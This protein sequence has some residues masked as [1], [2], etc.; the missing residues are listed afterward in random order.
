M[1]AGDVISRMVMDVSGVGAGLSNAEQQLNGFGGKMK[2]AG[3]AM[4]LALSAPLAAAKGYIVSQTLESMSATSQLRAQLGLTADEAANLGTVAKT[5]WSSGFGESITEATEAVSQVR[6]NMGELADKELEQVSKGAMML[7][8]VFQADVGES[9]AAAGVLM[10]NFKISAQDSFD[11]ITTGFQQGGDYSGEL[12]DTLREYSPQFSTMG[13]SADQ[14]LGI[15]IA[16]A[17]EGAWNLDKVGDAVKE[18]NIRAKDGSKT[19]VDGFA[20]IGLNAKQM[21]AAIAEGGEKG[22]QAFTATLA[23]LAAMEDPVKRNV[24]G[25]ALFGTQWED[26]ESK[27]V[28][29]MAEG[30]KGVEGFQ[31]STEKAMKSLEENNPAMAMKQ[32]V[33]ELTSSVEPALRPI[34]S[35]INDDVI[36]AAKSVTKWFTDLGPA[37]QKAALGIAALVLVSGPA[38]AGLGAV[39]GGASKV[40]TM[41]GKFRGASIAASV[42]TQGITTA[43]TTAT[44]VGGLAGL[45]TSLGA[46]A[47]AAGPWLLASAAIVGYSLS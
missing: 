40:I 20:A 4:S 35:I 43:T 33:R 11:L 22:Q 8:R 27:V 41:L 3:A 42:A 24:A 14:M 31:G 2:K 16:G 19:T 7:S 5:T 6:H 9:T 28:V 13:M 44:G 32:S 21:G 15:L 46:T 23:A 10:K 34:V 45:G 25:V 39:A 29:A 30:A 26:L 1:N 36:P 38:T 17:K 37:G 12:L 47:I 18:F